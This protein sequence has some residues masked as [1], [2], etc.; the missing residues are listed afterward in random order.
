MGNKIIN[1][2]FVSPTTSIPKTSKWNSKS[3]PLAKQNNNELVGK[4][5]GMPGKYWYKFMYICFVNIY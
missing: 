1:K 2:N 5:D 4:R 3:Q